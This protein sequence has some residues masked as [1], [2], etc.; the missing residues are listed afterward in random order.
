MLQLY[1]KRRGKRGKKA[2]EKDKKAKKS[3][4]A[5]RVQVDLDEL[6]LDETPNCSID[7]PNK[8]NLQLFY[9]KMVIDAR[10]S[11]WKGATYTFKFEI[12]DNYPYKPPKVTVNEKIYHPN[13][14]PNG[15]VCLNYLKKNWRPTLT[16]QH[17]IEGL[18]FL[19]SE[20]NPSDDPL[21]I[22]AADVMKKDLYTFI[23]NVNKPDTVPSL[24]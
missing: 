11:Y 20:P 22:N 5:L 7:I 10:D 14:D 18:I 24:L 16:I 3:P 6:D 17:V 8:E 23:S 13:I 9:V 15:R 12:P 4:G 2:A 21:N 1:G 19:F